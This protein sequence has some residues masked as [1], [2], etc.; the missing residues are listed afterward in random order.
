MTT[1]PHIEWFHGSPNK[2][3]ILHSGSTIT[4]ILILARAFSHKPEIL[5]IEV[6]E[7]ED[8]EIRKSKILHTPELCFHSRRTYLSSARRRYVS[9]FTGVMFPAG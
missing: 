2:L 3:N 5:S 7:N 6:N 9:T 1:K 8:T 4:P